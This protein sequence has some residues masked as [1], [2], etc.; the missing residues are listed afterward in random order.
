MCRHLENINNDFSNLT[1]AQIKLQFMQ[2]KMD[3][4]PALLE[5]YKS[6]ERSGV[7]NICR[8]YSSKYEEYQKEL[9]RIDSMKIY[10]RKY[11]DY[12]YI[13]GIDEAGRGPF[14]G[15]VIAAA[16]ILP[17][18]FDI[19]YI[20]D[21]KQISEKK[22]EELFDEIIKNAVSYGIGSVPPEKIDKINILN[23]TYAAMRQAI[24]NMK[25]KP[26][27]ILVDSLTIPEVHIPQVPIV[28]GDCKS[29]SIAAA[30]ILAKV[31]RDRLMVA[32]DKVF[33]GYGFAHNKGYGTKDHIEALKRL[34]PSPIH[35][36]SFIHDYI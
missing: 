33:P 15:P 6:D 32:Y 24:S 35:R 20:N 19:L 7:K 2:A 11:S 4:I 22:R 1:I 30:S 34:G 9:R 12:T 26:D 29:I 36:H 17:K 16:V 28:K 10:E 27:I 25:I 21:S 31:T 23:A 5:K 8:Q 14:A 18:D 3:S 13:C